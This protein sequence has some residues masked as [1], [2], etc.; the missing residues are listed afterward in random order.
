[1]T[2]A[3]AVASYPPLQVCSFQRGPCF[4][5][6]QSDVE[7]GSKLYSTA[8]ACVALSYVARFCS[9]HWVTCSA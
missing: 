1:M 9:V 3:S 6:L 2:L 4:P 8:D 7:F 5:A